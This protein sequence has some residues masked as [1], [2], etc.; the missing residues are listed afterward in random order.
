MSEI[1]I[2]NISQF[3]NALFNKNY[4]TINVN[5]AINYDELTS[6]CRLFSFRNY[7]INKSNGFYTVHFFFV[8]QKTINSDYVLQNSPKI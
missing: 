7:S 1:T 5:F 3:N 6:L 4:L 2:T 8:T